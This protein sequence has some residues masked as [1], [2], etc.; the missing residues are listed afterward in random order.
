MPACQRASVLDADKAE[1]FGW[2]WTGPTLTASARAG[3]GILRSGRE[4]KPAARSNKRN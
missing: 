1:P 4:K 2:P 3:L